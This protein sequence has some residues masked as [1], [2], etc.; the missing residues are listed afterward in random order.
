MPTAADPA[1]LVSILIPTFERPHLLGAAIDSALAQSYPHCEVLVG[2]D[3]RDER[4]A[5]LVR[6]HPE[7]ARIDYEHHPVP[8]GQAGNINRLFDRARGSRVIVLHDDDTLTP[9]AVE[10][11][12]QAWDRHEGIDACFAKQYVT[13]EDG[14]GRPA[15]SEALNRAYGRVREA[16]GLVPDPIRAALL[17]QLPGAGFLVDTALARRVRQSSAPHV[18]VVC[19]FEFGLRLGLASRAF[20]YVD[21]YVYNYRD[22]AAS[23]SS[24]VNSSGNLWQVLTELALPEQYERFRRMRLEAIAPAVVWQALSTGNVG[25]AREVMRSPYYPRRVAGAPVGLAQRALAYFPS[26]AARSVLR[27]ARRVRERMRGSA[28]STPHAHAS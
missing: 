10:L 2:D 24:T 3:S 6:A 15:D 8:L 17:Q 14:V 18:G 23:A 7:A 12:V 11:L 19:D 20:A 27:L 22:T 25:R 28:T 21:R 4:S 16:E 9:D 1:A 26:D 13:F 5:A